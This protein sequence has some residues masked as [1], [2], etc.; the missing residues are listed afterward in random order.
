[1]TW[2]AGPMNDSCSSFSLLYSASS[3]WADVSA[4]SRK[5]GISDRVLAIKPESIFPLQAHAL[6]LEVT[7]ESFSVACLTIMES[8]SAY[9]KLYYHILKML[10]GLF[11]LDDIEILP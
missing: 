7:F 5:S 1:M 10:P 8:V 11:V 6:K 4:L 9:S 2:H 3:A